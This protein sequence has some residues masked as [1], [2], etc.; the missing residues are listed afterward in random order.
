MDI[1][2]EV[3]VRVEGD[4]NR[5]MAHLSLDVFRALLLMDQQGGALSDDRSPDEFIHLPPRWC[6]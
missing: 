4:L 6:V 1:V 2:K 3:A 5:R